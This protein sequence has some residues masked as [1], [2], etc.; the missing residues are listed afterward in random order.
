MQIL[1]LLA[2]IF[3]VAS[4]CSASLRA[5]ADPLPSEPDQRK[6]EIV[7]GAT[8]RQLNVDFALFVPQG[9]KL[10]PGAPSFFA[11]YEKIGMGN[12]W[13]RVK[14]IKLNNVFALGNKIQLRERIE[15]SR[16]DSEIAL[17]ATVFHCGLD[18]KTACYIQGFQGST[19]RST[20][21]SRHIHFVARPT[22]DSF[23][24]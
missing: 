10:N 12:D 3:L 24:R 19:K 21:G 14:E 6:V 18:G 22:V 17:H 23:A 16:E 8:G 20:T 1:N 15:F 13:K 7:P 4:L 9:Q 11:V 5:E 2:S